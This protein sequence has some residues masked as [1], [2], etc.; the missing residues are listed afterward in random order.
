M[1]KNNQINTTESGFK[2]VT[3]IIIRAI[4]FFVILTS[5]IAILFYGYILIFNSY[6]L[7][8]EISLVANQFVSLK[9][10][11][12]IEILIFI[13]IFIGAVFTLYSNRKGFIFVTVG[14]ILLLAMNTL[15]FE[16]VDLFNSSIAAIV[17]LL[18]FIS[19]KINK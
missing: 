11:I 16:K 15:Y 9:T 3:P 12:F 18:V 2:K 19:W 10:Y 4:S 14:V 7:S 13:M 5:S 17:L 6:V 8:E 1:E